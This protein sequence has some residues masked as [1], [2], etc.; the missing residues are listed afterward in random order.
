MNELTTQA[1]FN[2]NT[3]KVIAVK[4]NN[5][6]FG[7]DRKEKRY[8]SNADYSRDMKAYSRNLDD[9]KYGDR[10]GVYFNEPYLATQIIL[11]NMKKYKDF[12]KRH[13]QEVT[14]R[15]KDVYGDHNYT[16]IF[17]DEKFAAFVKQFVK[18]PTVHPVVTPGFIKEYLNFLFRE[19][20][21]NMRLKEQ[22]LQDLY[23]KACKPVLEENSGQP[24]F[25][26]GGFER[27]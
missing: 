16:L 26:G 27:S 14:Y 12:A 9:F 17:I 21:E 10:K 3:G 19:T 7:L 20:D 2:I 8:H 6:D 25:V 22:E 4:L 13:V 18:L 5:K 15:Y 11:T 23:D 1:D 24:S